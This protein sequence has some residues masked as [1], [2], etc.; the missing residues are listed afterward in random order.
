MQSTD[1][2]GRATLSTT[3]LTEKE[4][5][6][7][8]FAQ[9][10][11]L[12]LIHTH[13]DLRVLDFLLKGGGLRNEEMNDQPQPLAP[14]PVLTQSILNTWPDAQIIQL[15]DLSTGLSS[16]IPPWK[17]AVMPKFDLIKQHGI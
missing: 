9:T 14:K 2:L 3:A 5:G 8:M 12:H 1:S 7:K 13:F 11:C 4:V 15:I 10:T 6:R 16:A 17:F